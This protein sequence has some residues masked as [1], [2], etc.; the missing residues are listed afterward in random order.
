MSSRVIPSINYPDV[1]PV[2]NTL[3]VGPVLYKLGGQFT[4]IVA[5]YS[6]DLNCAV[7]FSFKARRQVTTL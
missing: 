4:M 3:G 1:G 2:S 5:R 6:L 7:I